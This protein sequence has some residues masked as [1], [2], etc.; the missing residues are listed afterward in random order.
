MHHHVQRKSGAE[1]RWQQHWWTAWWS[2]RTVEVHRFVVWYRRNYSRLV[3]KS[4]ILLSEDHHA[5]H[6]ILSYFWLFN[7]L[8]VNHY[9]MRFNWY[10]FSISVTLIIKMLWKCL[11][12]IHPHPSTTMIGSH[13]P[14]AQGLSTL[15][16][17]LTYIYIM[18]ICIYI[19][20][21]RIA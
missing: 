3:F 18:I 6:V 12:M 9:N 7:L 16:C 5:F 2:K 10:I 20:W 8:H 4:Y 1:G 21:L 17:P 14:H 15:V 13:W 19:Q 11:S